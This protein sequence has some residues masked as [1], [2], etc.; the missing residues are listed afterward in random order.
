VGVQLGAERG[1]QRIEHD[2]YDVVRLDDLAHPLDV[3]RQLQRAVEPFGGV[4]I[5][6]DHLVE[7]GTG[8][9]ESGVDGLSPRIL[10]CAG[11][12]RLRVSEAFAWQGVLG[13][14]GHHVGHHCGLPDAFSASDQ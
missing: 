6:P 9:D 5:D 10:S 11:D 12:H 4:G 2:Q 7:I 3:F 14:A 1:H 13:D 8:C